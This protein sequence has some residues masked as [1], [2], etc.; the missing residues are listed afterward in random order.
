SKRSE[1]FGC[2]HIDAN[3]EVFPD[4]SERHYLIQRLS[5]AQDLSLLLENPKLMIYW[6][7]GK[8][9]RQKCRDC[10]FRHAC[11]NP[12]PARSITDDI[13][14]APSNCTYNLELGTW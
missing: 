6:S 9:K 3:R 11:P 5:D 1:S 4:V 2:I 13:Y 10:E 7:A 14:S 12:I 8:D